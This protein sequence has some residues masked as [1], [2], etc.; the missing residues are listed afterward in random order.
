MVADRNPTERLAEVLD[1]CEEILEAYLFGSRA[2]GQARRHSDLDIAVYIDEAFEEFASLVE[3]SLDELVRVAAF[4]TDPRQAAL[5]T[6]LLTASDTEP[7]KLARRS[8]WPGAV[9][10]N[11]YIRAC[12]TRMCARWI[13]TRSWNS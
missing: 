6:A 10:S 12:S 11:L 1:P 9:R 5:D 13:A 8:R 2:R 4:R 7:S 3:R